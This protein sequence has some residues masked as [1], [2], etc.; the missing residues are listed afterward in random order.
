MSNW[1]QLGI[2][3]HKVIEKLLEFVRCDIIEG[4]SKTEFIIN[5]LNDACFNPQMCRTQTFNEVGNM[6]GKEKDAVK[7]CSKTE[8]KKS[9]L[10]HFASYE[11]I[12]ML[13]TIV[14]IVSTMQILCIFSSIFR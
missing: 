10:F 4:E 2:F 3:V 7:L 5:A 14:N 13:I 11:L 8:K 1:D 9:V 6:A 12:F